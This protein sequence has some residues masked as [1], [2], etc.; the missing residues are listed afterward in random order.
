[1]EA[2]GLNY[3]V[4]KYVPPQLKTAEMCM[5]AVKLNYRSLQHVPQQLKTTEMC[6]DAIRRSDGR[7]RVLKHLSQN[8]DAVAQSRV[9]SPSPSVTGT[10]RCMVGS[11]TS[12]RR[13][14]LLNECLIPTGG[15]PLFL[16]G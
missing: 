9:R 12:P 8:H 16:R 4:L 7:R 13:L 1:M 3:R 14:E 6:M 15:H 10:S 5:E 11:K 2:V